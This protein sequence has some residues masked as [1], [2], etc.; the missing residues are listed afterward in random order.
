MSKARPPRFGEY[1]T[2]KEWKTLVG[3]WSGVSTAS[4]TDLHALLIL[5]IE[6]KKA[7]SEVIKRANTINSMESLFKVLDKLYKSD[8]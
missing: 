6:N 8:N 1:D 5:Q 2:Y 7:K 3:I 4:K